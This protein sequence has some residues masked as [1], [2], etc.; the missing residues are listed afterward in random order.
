MMTPP[1][2]DL[3]N[4]DPAQLEAMLDH[5][6][7]QLEELMAN[8]KRHLRDEAS[9][10][11]AL[12]LTNGALHVSAVAGFVAFACHSIGAARLERRRQE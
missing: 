10:Q 1:K 8:V 3:R 12:D 4:P 6:A 11:N 9:E 2:F 5:L 7:V